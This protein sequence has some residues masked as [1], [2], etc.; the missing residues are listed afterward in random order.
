[1]ISFTSSILCWVLVGLVI[2]FCCFFVIG[3]GE[4]EASVMFFGMVGGIVTIVIFTHIDWETRCYEIALEDYADA[5]N[6]LAEARE[7]LANSN[8]DS[9]TI[10]VKLTPLIR[11]SLKWADALNE[12]A[13]SCRVTPT[14]ITVCH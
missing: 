14:G 6:E 1:M 7:E 11:D 9:L 10:Q 2:I 8:L 3:M 4:E 5:K 13:N 12:V